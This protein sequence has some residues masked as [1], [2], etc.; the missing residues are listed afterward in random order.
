MVTSASE[1]SIYEKTKGRVCTLLG[2][3]KTRFRPG[4]AVLMNRLWSTCRKSL[5]FWDMYP[6]RRVRLLVKGFDCIGC[7]LDYRK[8]ILLEDLGLPTRL[9]GLGRRIGLRMWRRRSGRISMGW[10]SLIRNLH[11]L[12]PLIKLDITHD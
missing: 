9:L 1:D 7:H 11:L 8:L 12:N 5:S 10:W 4:K 6:L 3:L 2:L